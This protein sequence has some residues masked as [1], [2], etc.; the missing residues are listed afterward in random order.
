MKKLLVFIFVLF[1]I[2][3]Y[4]QTSQ[5]HPFPDSAAIWN[6]ESYQSCGLFFDIWNYSYS[7]IISGDTVLNGKSYHKLNVPLTVVTSNGSCNSSGT[8]TILGHYAG[9]IRQD[10]SIKKVFFIFPSDSVELL[11]YDFNLVVGDTVKGL[12]GIYSA[13][14]VQSIDSILIGGDYRK[15]WVINPCYGIYLIEGIGSTY[16]LIESSPGCLSEGNNYTISCFKQN[17]FTLYPDNTTNCD[18]INSTKNDPPKI[19]LVTISPNPFHTSTLI[20]VS[21]EFEYTDLK[22][23]N[24]LGILVYEE[25]ISKKKSFLLNRNHFQAGVYFLQLIGRNGQTSNKQFVVE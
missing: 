20:E 3:T 7:I 2:T 4:S 6:I 24:N 21:A 11:L 5:Y 12:I 13:D 25:E 9:C 18:I 19:F 8:W 17:N 15:R 1:V 22:I 10:T 23:Y 14:V 16:G